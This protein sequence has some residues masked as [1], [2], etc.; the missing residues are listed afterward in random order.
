MCT[1][2]VGSPAMLMASALYGAG[3]LGRGEELRGLL[4]GAG[5]GQRRLRVLLSAMQSSGVPVLVATGA[6]QRDQLVRSWSG[7]H[8][9]LA[10]G[11]L[12]QLMDDGMNIIGLA[13][14]MGRPVYVADG[15]AGFLP[16]GVRHGLDGADGEALTCLQLWV[17]LLCVADY[18]HFAR[19]SWCSGQEW[20]QLLNW[21][22]G[23][24]TGDGDGFKNLRNCNAASILPIGLPVNT[25]FKAR[26]LRL[27]ML[28]EPGFET[29][30]ATLQGPL[31]ASTR[32]DRS[33]A[34]S[35]DESVAET[36]RKLGDPG[37]M[38]QQWRRGV[39]LREL[40]RL[41]DPGGAARGVLRDLLPDSVLGPPCDVIAP[42]PPALPVHCG[43]LHPGLSAADV[44]A[45]VRGVGAPGRPVPA[46]E[47][48]GRC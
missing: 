30:L 42:L 19:E 6:K 29:R 24:S 10:A 28:L 13:Q 37:E 21:E 8:G 36:M 5:D 23:R 4:Q 34:P 46:R 48:R 31:P 39:L 26:L 40:V 38:V 9:K 15:G 14:P 27:G 25:L 16:A 17:R 3:L 20:S 1:L 22:L 41:S 43:S 32:R 47:R 33:G 18:A 44:L 11:S 12:L 2:N 35:L 7:I 45:L